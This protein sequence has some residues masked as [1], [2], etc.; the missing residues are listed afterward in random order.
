[1]WHY[2]Y[3]KTRCGPVTLNEVLD[4]YDLIANEFNRYKYWHSS[5]KTSC[6]EVFGKKGVLRNFAKFNG[7]H[8]CQNL[9]L[10]KVAILRAATSLKRDSGTGVFL[11][12]LRNS[13]L[14]F[15]TP[16][17]LLEPLVQILYSK[18]H[19]EPLKTRLK[20]V[21]RCQNFNGL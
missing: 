7:K 20:E 5:L 17:M 16:P 12:I 21:L 13:T 11:S 1:M 8:L 14:S 6:P 10:N 3:K 9:F 2:Q 18:M 15:R 19:Y 4:N